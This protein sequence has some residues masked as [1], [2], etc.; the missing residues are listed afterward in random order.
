MLCYAVDTTNS[1]IPYLGLL[2]VREKFLTIFPQGKFNGVWSSEELKFAKEYGY[3]I[4]VIK[5]Y[6]FSKTKNLFTDYINDMYK[7]KSENKGVKKAIAKSLL[8]NLLGRFG[9]NVYS[10]IT[11]WVNKEK[12]EYIRRTREVKNIVD[13][14]EDTYK[15]TYINIVDEFICGVAENGI[16]YEKIREKEHTGFLNKTDNFRDVSVSISAMVTAYDRIHIQKL[17]IDILN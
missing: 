7:I 11:E 6:N 5:G 12:M 3:D 2:P 17:K 9:L 10:S 13:L 1:K 8:N 4:K 14:N 15:I 16:N